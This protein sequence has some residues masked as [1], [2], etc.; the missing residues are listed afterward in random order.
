MIDECGSVGG[1]T[2]TFAKY[3][4]SHAFRLWHF[5]EVALVALGGR[6]PFKSGL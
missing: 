3:G 2:Q 6:S 5:S 4:D 1:M